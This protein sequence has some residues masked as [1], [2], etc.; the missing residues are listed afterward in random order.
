MEKSLLKK[1]LYFD[2]KPMLSL[3]SNI[4]WVEKVSHAPIK[5][6]ITFGVERLR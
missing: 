3:V 5:G 4:Y 1:S 2:Q 6:S